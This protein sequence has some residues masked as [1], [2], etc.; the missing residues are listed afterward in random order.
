MAGGLWASPSRRWEG[1]LDFGFY[2]DRRTVY[3]KPSFPNQPAEAHHK[4]DIWHARAKASVLT[5]VADHDFLR[6]WIPRRWTLRAGTGLALVHTS[7]SAYV[8]GPTAVPPVDFPQT[9]TTYLKPLFE[10]G[11]RIPV[12]HRFDVDVAMEWIPSIIGPDDVNFT[13]LASS[14]RVVF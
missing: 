8:S 12:S 3:F 5:P 4:I 14:V 13:G 11:F 9:D 10:G 6:G 2:S 7:D 1:A